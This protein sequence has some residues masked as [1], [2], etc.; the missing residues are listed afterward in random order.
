MQ[1]QHVCLFGKKKVSKSP[2]MDLSQIIQFGYRWTLT[3][4]WFIGPG[5]PWS[6]RE[7]VNLSLQQPEPVNMKARRRAEFER[8]VSTFGCVW[9]GGMLEQDG[10]REGER[11][12]EPRDACMLY[13]TAR[14]NLSAFTQRGFLCADLSEF[15][16]VSS[17]AGNLNIHEEFLFLVKASCGS[18]E[19]SCATA[20]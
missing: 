10:E 4:V 13:S 9:V 20:G 19:A 18:T 11:E 15:C 5:H 1:P 17:S 14:V 2:G 8:A 7:D 6:K 16:C 12:R 3:F